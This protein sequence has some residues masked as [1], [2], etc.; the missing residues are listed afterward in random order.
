MSPT[1]RLRSSAAIRDVFAGRHAS[2]STHV[3]T[4]A[5]RRDDSATAVA[6][7]AGR[8]VGN[9]VL[10]NRVKRRLRACLA[11]TDLPPGVDLVISGKSGADTAPFGQLRN[12]VSGSIQRAV[13]RV[14]N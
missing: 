9:A 3:V 4:H 12:E 5:R 10:R 7:I 14:M 6:V 13:R 1:V 2:G 11:A 8:R